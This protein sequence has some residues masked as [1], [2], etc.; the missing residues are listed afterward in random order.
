LQSSLHGLYLA[1]HDRKVAAQLRHF[2]WKIG[3]DSCAAPF[4]RWKDVAALNISS[5]PSR[6]THRRMQ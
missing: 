3:L 6:L 1:S 4:P 5:C 2:A